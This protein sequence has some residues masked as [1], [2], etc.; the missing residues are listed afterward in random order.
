[1]TT[2][3]TFLPTT[4][5]PTPVTVPL[6]ERLRHLAATR[7]MQRAFTF[8]DHAGSHPADPVDGV[9]RTV[10]WGRLDKRVRAVAAHLAGTVPPGERVALLMPQGLDYVTGFLACLYAGVVA[11]PLYPPESAAHADRLATILDDCE[12]ECVLT[13]STAMDRVRSFVGERHTD[14]VAVLAADEPAE[15]PGG[16]WAPAVPV[17]LDDIAYLQYTSGSTRSPAGVR[18]THRNVIANARQALAAYGAE[19]GMATTVGWLPLFHDMGLVL[20]VAAPIVGGFPSVL[21]DPM[22]FLRRPARWLRLLAQYPGAISAAPNFAYD[23][24]ASRVGE[25]EKNSL[26]LH[27]VKALINGSEPVRAATLERFAAAFAGQGLRPETLSPS[28]GLAEATVFVA[29]ATPFTRPPVTVTLDRAALT[30]GKVVPADDDAPEAARLVTCGAPVGQQLLIVDP[31][32]RMPLAEGQVGE[33]WVQGPNVGTGYRGRPQLSA[34]TFAARARQHLGRWLRTGDLG[35]MHEGS[36]LV[37]G[38]LKDLIIVDGRNHYPQDIEETVQTACPAVRRDHVA[39][40]SVP[41]GEDGEQVVVVAEHSRRDN[42]PQEPELAAA[43]RAVRAAVSTRHGVRLTAFHL[44]RPGLI[45]RTTS[46]KVARSAC[47]GSYL[48]GVLGTPG[49]HA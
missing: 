21:M 15:Q 27:R 28:Y 35:A 33:I 14:R 2:E 31:E 1:M 11:V 24:C 39:A 48:T 41:G 9:H 46:G 3:L 42:S 44:V 36:L 6:T 43:E 29:A 38:R 23:L 18:I 49:R 25:E 32:T 34:E 17:Y 40:F 19:D 26:R 8:V 16:P 5:V 22:A 7:G 47:R 37:T 45:P 10:T 20:S 13:H 4:E 12:P 30:E